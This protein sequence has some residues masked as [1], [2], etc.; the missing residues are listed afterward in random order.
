MGPTAAGS[1]EVK[2]KTQRKKGGQ[3]DGVPLQVFSPVTDLLWI[4]KYMTMG[5]LKYGL[6]KKHCTGTRAGLSP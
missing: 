3:E 2:K 6:R 4:S 1:E 5:R